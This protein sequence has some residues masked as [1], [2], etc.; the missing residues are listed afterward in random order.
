MRNDNDELVAKNYPKKKQPIIQ[1]LKFKPPNCP[2]C[3]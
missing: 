2:S 1:Q 3:K